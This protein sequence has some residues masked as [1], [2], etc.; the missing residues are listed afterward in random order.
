M[1]KITAKIRFMMT[2]AEMIA[3]RCADPL[4]WDNCWD[5]FGT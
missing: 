5:Q 4:G 1:P 3:N 2:P